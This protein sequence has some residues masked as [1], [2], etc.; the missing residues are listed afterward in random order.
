MLFRF[1]S[2]ERL[3]IAIIDHGLFFISIWPESLEAIWIRYRYP[4]SFYLGI[5]LV[6]EYHDI[7]QW[8]KDNTSDYDLDMRYS[9]NPP[10]GSKPWMISQGEIR[11]RDLSLATMFSMRFGGGSRG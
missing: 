5:R 9:P 3:A 2:L 7:N 8:M 1:A 11:F 10:K 4:Y 6:L